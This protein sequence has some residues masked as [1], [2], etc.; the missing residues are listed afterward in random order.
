MIYRFIPEY[1]PM[2]WGSELWVLSGYD[3]RPTRVADGEFKGLTVNELIARKGA[4]LM[5]ERVYE[6]FG[7]EFP[8]LVKFIDAKQDLSIQ[9]HPG[10]ALAQARHGGHG[11][12]E[13]WYVIRADEGAHLYSGISK[14]LDAEKYVRLVEQDRIVEVLADHK[15][16]SGDVFFLP[17]GRIHA[18]C[19]GT[20]LAEIQQ[21]SDLTYRIYDYKRPGADGKPRQLHTELA[22][23]AIDYT[24]YPEYRTRYEYN[25]NGESRLVDCEYFHTSMYDLD[26]PSCIDLSSLDTCLMV[27]C[28]E[29]SGSVG[30]VGV[31]AGEA[32]LVDAGTGN[33]ELVP[34]GAMKLLTSYV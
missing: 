5:G 21:T 29:G 9:V 8:L 10:E 17:A 6:R 27:M 7:N 12:T 31:K 33:V 1:R 4:E 18:I 2:I 22:K 30:G 25:S 11:K 26:S 19:G 24:V 15:I 16:S 34:S 23:D 20:Y 28:I 13:M 3:E 32:L 14:E